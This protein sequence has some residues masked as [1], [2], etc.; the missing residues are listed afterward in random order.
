M[1]CYL[2]QIHLSL[3]SQDLRGTQVLRWVGCMERCYV[4]EVELLLSA[5][6]LCCHGDPAFTREGV[7]HNLGMALGSRDHAP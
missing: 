6:R 5:R 1:G 2:N 7:I 3:R 4:V